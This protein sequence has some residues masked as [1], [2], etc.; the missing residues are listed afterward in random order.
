MLYDAKQVCVRNVRDPSLPRFGQPKL[1]ICFK[2]TGKRTKAAELAQYHPDVLMQ[3]QKKAWYDGALCNKWAILA[4]ME[5]ILKEEGPHLVLSDNLG[6]QTT[7]EF[8]KILL[9]DCAQFASV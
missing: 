5:F 1:V 9:C 7:D 3:W 8:K 2:G 4:S 6:G